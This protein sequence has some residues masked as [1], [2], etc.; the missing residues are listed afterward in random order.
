M[1]YLYI[2]NNTRGMLWNRSH[3]LNTGIR[4]A[5][6]D[7]VITSDVDLIFP[8]NFIN[9]MLEHLE[10]GTELHCN[11][12]ALPKN[13]RQYELLFKKQF[14]FKE[15]D[16]TA[17]GLVQGVKRDVL[18]ELHGFDEFY[19]IY[20]A[21]DTDLNLRLALT[22]LQTKWLPLKE[23]PI[24]HQWH[25]SSVKRTRS[26]IP[27]GWGKF[28]RHY[29]ETNSQVLVRNKEG[30]GKVYTDSNRMILQKDIR[31]FKITDLSELPEMAIPFIFSEV[32]LS[33]PNGSCSKFF[34]VDKHQSN[35]KKSFIQNLVRRF[36]NLSDYFNLPLMFTSEMHYYGKYYS[37]Y[38]IKDALIYCLVNNMHHI[39][40]YFLS[41]TSSQVELMVVKK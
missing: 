4:I 17:L 20:G 24:Y 10:N 34:F 15:R 22:G 2:Y 26:R 14:R 38:D 7:F 6:T 31:I 12:Y 25:P 19:Q 21:E 18:E 41:F 37:A 8:D 29:M 28:I 32:L 27:L 33:T 9:K 3:A 39:E 5:D 16:L 30:W 1:G 23:V 11:A 36:N 13:F 35:F 40:D